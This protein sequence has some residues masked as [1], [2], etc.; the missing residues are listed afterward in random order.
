MNALADT[1]RWLALSARVEPAQLAA[2]QRGRLVVEVEI[3][4]GCHIEAHAPAEPFLVPTELGFEPA[5]GLVIGPVEYPPAEA[6]QFDWSAMV[7][8]VYRGTLRLEAPLALAAGAAP[9]SR[10]IRGRL[11]YQGCTPTACLMPSTQPVEAVL[12]VAPPRQREDP[13]PDLDA[14]RGG[15][16]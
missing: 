12:E 6:K 16:P 5:D 3:P 4:E 14:D 11:R 13:R 8:R 15:R 1:S 9:G 7:L 10:R 2:G